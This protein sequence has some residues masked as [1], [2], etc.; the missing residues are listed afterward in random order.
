M[1]NP[2]M[3]LETHPEDVS[4]AP[5]LLEFFRELE[6]GD[7]LD[8]LMTT[9][10]P[11]AEV[12]HVAGIDITD[13]GLAQDTIVALEDLADGYRRLFNLTEFTIVPERVEMFNI[14]KEG[15]RS[16]FTDDTLHVNTPLCAMW[17]LE[18]PPRHVDMVF[19]E[20]NH[21]VTL[22]KDEVWFY[23]ESPNYPFV[24]G[25]SDHTTCVICV[26]Y[27]ITLA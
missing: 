16:S 15:M 26:Q 11:D 17:V 25:S 19:T 3:I 5:D 7:S 4:V 21:T 1:K 14:P 6:S 27:E 10:T 9:T 20:Q 2:Q 18:E 8:T 13:T 12:V 24:I 23:P 22:N